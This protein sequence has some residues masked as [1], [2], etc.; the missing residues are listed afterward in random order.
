[1]QEKE[2]VSFPEAVRLVAEKMDIE[3]P[4]TKPQ[5]ASEH[6]AKEARQRGQFIEIHER[7]AKFFEDQLRGPEA[8]HARQYLAGRG[9]S[10]ETIHAFHIGYA[11]DSGFT[12][13]D[14]LKND[15]SEE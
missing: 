3:L 4:R 12:L 2:N 5:Y 14:R 10:E 6:E 1:L 9:L 7:A 13:R 15:F 8:A 11:P